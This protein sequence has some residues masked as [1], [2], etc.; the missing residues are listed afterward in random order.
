MLTS[1]YVGV[2]NLMSVATVS[3]GISKCGSKSAALFFF[4]QI[5]V[6]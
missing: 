1:L 3:R 4:F 6:V 2:S 5:F